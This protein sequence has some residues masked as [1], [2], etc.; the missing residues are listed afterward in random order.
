MGFFVWGIISL[1]ILTRLKDFAV[2][3]AFSK[4]NQSALIINSVSFGVRVH[5]DFER[6]NVVRS[7]LLCTISKEA[8]SLKELR[9]I[10]GKC[11]WLES[12]HKIGQIKNQKNLTELC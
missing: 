1:Q 6:V 5:H 7:L 10:I 8:L 3:A 4:F 11:L 12:I 9:V 2:F